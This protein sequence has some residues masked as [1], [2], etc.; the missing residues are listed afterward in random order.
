[1][2]A[3][4]PLGSSRLRHFALRGHAAL[5]RCFNKSHRICGIRTIRTASSTTPNLNS[6]FSAKALRAR[7]NGAFKKIVMWRQAKCVNS[8]SLKPLDN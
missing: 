7:P 6:A 4:L 1:M 5:L 3:K 2:V 8:G